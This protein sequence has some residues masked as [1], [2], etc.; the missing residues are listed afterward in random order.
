MK[1]K[2]TTLEKITRKYLEKIEKIALKSKGE[3]H[4]NHI[5]RNVAGS[6]PCLQECFN[7]GI[8]SWKEIKPRYV[9]SL[10]KLKRY[11]HLIENFSEFRYAELNSKSG[12]YPEIGSVFTPEELF[13]KGVKS[14]VEYYIDESKKRLKESI[15]E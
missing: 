9:N 3:N 2:K 4:F 10:I 5:S 14:G 11:F 1:M 7:E 6:I 13:K 8:K 15:R 12:Y